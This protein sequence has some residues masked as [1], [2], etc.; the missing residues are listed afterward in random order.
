LVQPGWQPVPLRQKIEADDGAAHA[1]YPLETDVI[2]LYYIRR[3][4]PTVPIEDTI[5]AMSDLVR[6]GEYAI[7]RS[8]FAPGKVG[9][10]N[11]SP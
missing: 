1:D 7:S 8:G 4:D 6:H 10:T 3:V 11:A 9:V 5:G 2:D